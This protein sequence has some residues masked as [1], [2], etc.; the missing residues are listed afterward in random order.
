MQ[1][2]SGWMQH[3]FTVGLYGDSDPNNRNDRLQSSE[4]EH[5]EWPIRGVPYR[6]ALDD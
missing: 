6:H 2:I 5:K 3:G 1:L 4:R